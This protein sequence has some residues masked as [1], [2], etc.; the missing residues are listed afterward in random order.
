MAKNQ[1]NVTIPANLMQLINE[2]AKD[3][4]IA[5]AAVIREAISTT[6]KPKYSND[7]ELEK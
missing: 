7:K 1:F 3:K 4:S 5:K 2:A 6:L